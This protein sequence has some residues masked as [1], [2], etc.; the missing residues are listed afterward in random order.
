MAIYGMSSSIPVFSPGS[1]CPPACVVSFL[2]SSGRLGAHIPVRLLWSPPIAP[3]KPGMSTASVIWMSTRTYFRLLS[4]WP[5][6]PFWEVRTDHLRRL[7]L[8]RPPVYP[9]RTAN[10]RRHQHAF[11]GLLFIQNN[12]LIS[13]PHERH[14]QLRNFAGHL[15]SS[16]PIEPCSLGLQAAE[17]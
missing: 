9:L 5:Q 4:A 16:L 3:S 11:L 15:L 2:L 10:L 14:Q 8:L 12:F 1:I 7:L 6:L 17:L 13:S